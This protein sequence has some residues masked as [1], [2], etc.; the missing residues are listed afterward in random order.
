MYH[1]HFQGWKSAKQETSVQQAARQTETSVHLWTTWH[2]ISEDRNI[3]KIVNL[4]L[5]VQVKDTF[6]IIA[7]F[8]VGSW[9]GGD[10]FKSQ[11]ADERIVLK[12]MLIVTF[13]R[14]TVLHVIG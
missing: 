1:L 12:W 3:Q 14:R 6:W 10:C 7:L 8:Q 4:F 5:A 13:S 2:C 11:G 9:K